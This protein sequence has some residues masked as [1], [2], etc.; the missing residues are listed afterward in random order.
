MFH[1]ITSAPR[2]PSFLV[3]GAGEALTGEPVEMVATHHLAHGELDAYQRVLQDAMAGDA[4]LFARQDYIEEAWRII[5]P[6]LT[7]DSPVYEYERRTWGP[8][9]VDRFVRPEGGWHNPVY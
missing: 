6:V 4:V 8:A 7:F 1:E 9:E 2:L 3:L 5:D